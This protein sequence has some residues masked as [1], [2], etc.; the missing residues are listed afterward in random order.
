LNIP[1]STLKT[2]KASALANYKRGNSKGGRPR[3]LDETGD[4]ELIE[5]VN[6][7]VDIQQSKARRAFKR[8]VCELHEATRERK[9]LCCVGSIVINTK[10][11]KR[12]RKRLKIKYTSGQTKTDARVRAEYD[13]R[14][15]V[16]NAVMFYYKALYL[17]PHE[18][19]NW[20]GVQFAIFKENNKLLC[21]I[22]PSA[23]HKPITGVSDSGTG[24]YIKYIITSNA[25]GMTAPGVFVLQDSSMEKGT[26]A[27]YKVWGLSHNTDADA[28]GYLIVCHSR[29]LN[30][31][32]Y[33]WYILN[34]VIPFYSTVRERFVVP[35]LW[36]SRL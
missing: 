22:L 10:T 35:Q 32:A 18:L 36:V 16:A 20:D 12:L 1:I 34:I 5:F 19:G 26:F 27:V 7:S 25:A 33:E 31:N 6:S 13:F 17:S 2:Y 4:N 30:D 24:I 28:Y 11:M 3:T 29:A 21:Y 8:K 9:G 14:N 15:F 23:Q